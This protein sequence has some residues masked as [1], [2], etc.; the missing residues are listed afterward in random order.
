MASL[1]HLRRHACLSTA[2]AH[3]APM[4]MRP[5]LV[6]SCKML[7]VP[8]A[9]KPACKSSRRPRAPPPMSASSTPEAPAQPEGTER[10]GEDAAVFELS[11]QKLQS[12]AVFGVLL[13]SVLGLLYALWIR[14]M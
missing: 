12:W 10:V 14:P 1:S 7:N 5:M 6:N 8:Y 4:P 9:R 3:V 11:Q 2:A 13:T